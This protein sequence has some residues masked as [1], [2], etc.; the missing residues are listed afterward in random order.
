MQDGLFS[1]IENHG[2]S[3]LVVEQWGKL[4][5]RESSQLQW[6]K[7]LDNYPK[8]LVT[9]F[10]KEGMVQPRIRLTYTNETDLRAFGIWY[11][12]ESGQFSFN[13]IPQEHL[14]TEDRVNKGRY[15]VFEADSTIT[16]TLEPIID[17]PDQF[18]ELKKPLVG[19]VPSLKREYRE[20][21][22]ATLVLVLQWTQFS[23]ILSA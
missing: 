12:E 11:K 4:I 8:K 5:Q 3:I 1:I 15:W 10:T 14:K 6:S 19:L 7:D 20:S 9:L 17:M 21:R 2:D 13:N 23:T 16:F 22:S 18:K